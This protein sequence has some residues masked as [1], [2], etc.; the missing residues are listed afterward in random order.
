MRKNTGLNNM[1]V[2]C[3]FELYRNLC[4]ELRNK[5]HLIF[6]MDEIGVSFNL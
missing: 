3:F 2:D 5:L 1:A 6:N 4:T